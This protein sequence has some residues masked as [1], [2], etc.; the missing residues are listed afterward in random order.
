MV[1]GELRSEVVL[2][3]VSPQAGRRELLTLLAQTLLLFTLEVERESVL[4]LPLLA[5]VVR[6]LDQE[7]VALRDVPLLTGV[8]K[9]AVSMAL[10]SLVKAGFVEV[11]GAG[12]SSTLALTT[13][14]LAARQADR[15]RVGAV[16]QAWAKEGPGD[17]AA[18]RAASEELL[19]QGSD[20]ASA[21][22]EG[23]RPD[24]GTWRAHPRYRAHTEAL[25]ADPRAVLP[26][27]PMVLHR[28]GCPDGS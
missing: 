14:G 11:T 17:L 7:P 24:E 13:A 2:S 9:E 27:H 8:S 28:G 3:G 20:P 6:I 16:E 19:Q 1:S 12:V 15:H 18:L 10:T 21:M 4:S 23:L 22:A 5:N 26:H 25:L